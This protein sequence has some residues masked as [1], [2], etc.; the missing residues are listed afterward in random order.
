MKK[1][2]AVSVHGPGIQRLPRAVWGPHNLTAGNAGCWA[3]AQ[4]GG[5]LPHMPVSAHTAQGTD[6]S[7]LSQRLLYLLLTPPAITG[8][9][10]IWLGL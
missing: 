4:A 9:F 8:I 10:T 7:F 5:A 6:R 1:H 2:V 3:S